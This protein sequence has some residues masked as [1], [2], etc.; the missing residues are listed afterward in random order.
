MGY[1]RYTIGLSEGIYVVVYE[2]MIGYGW[3]TVGL[4]EGIL[5]GGVWVDVCLGY[6]GL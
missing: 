2:W 1:L 3:Y 6:M 5:P 4:S